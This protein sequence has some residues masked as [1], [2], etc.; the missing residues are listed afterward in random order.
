MAVPTN[1]HR[2]FW[3]I[4]CLALGGCAAPIVS[5]GGLFSRPTSASSAGNTSQR[6]LTVQTDNDAGDDSFHRPAERQRVATEE[7]LGQVLDDLEEIR[8]V[9][10]RAQ[11]QLLAEL[12]KAPPHKWPLMVQ[13]FRSALEHREELRH[14]LLDSSGA[15]KE[16]SY[17]VADE[18][19]QLN[20]A[21]RTAARR[22]RVTTEVWDE[23]S[24][25]QPLSSDLLTPADMPNDHDPAAVFASLPPS[26]QHAES[27]RSGDPGRDPEV[28]PALFLSDG[29][30]RRVEPAIWRE[31]PARPLARTS[32]T[33]PVRLPAE[34]SWE[35]H[36]NAAIGA[37]SVAAEEDQQSAPDSPNYVRLRL[38]QLVAE[39]TNAAMAPIP[40]LSSAEQGYWTKQLFALATYTESH[41]HLDQEQRATLAAKHL[42]DALSQLRELGNLR[43]HNLAFC[44]QVYDFG[45]YEAC[46][47]NRFP[48]GRQVTLYAEVE[49]YR[50]RP[51]EKGFHT[52]LASSYEVVTEKGER[53][54]GGEFPQV[55]DYCRNRRRDFHIQYTLPVPSQ[56]RP[57]NYRLKLTILDNLS[58]KQGH[59]A[60]DFQIVDP[61]DTAH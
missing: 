35:Q 12:K 22:A 54:A 40:N 23:E 9:D 29:D 7:A 6:V 47:M 30:E 51:T 36:L 44:E 41:A 49:N 13:Q 28:S 60:I 53:V 5:E 11:Q 26:P 61:V 52:S 48:A 57:G 24:E 32:D 33:A 10:R 38:L 31:E 39:D 56:G 59:N 3:V 27:T 50:S 25:T 37:L 16:S 1:Y 43:V 15:S 8:S 19:D 42:D 58:G 46:P 4:L 34:V 20:N 45:A 55:E 18:V 17:A 14:Q 2:F 21:W